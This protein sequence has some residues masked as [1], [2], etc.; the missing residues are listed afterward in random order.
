MITLPQD[1]IWFGLLIAVV[2]QAICIC[3][4]ICYGVLSNEERA[5]RMNAMLLAMCIF[6]FATG[7][8]W[9]ALNLLEYVK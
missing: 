5:D 1:E 6:V 4:L 8:T 9:T 2:I 7:P 3:P